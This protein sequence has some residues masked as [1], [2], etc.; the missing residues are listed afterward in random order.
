MQPLN[1]AWRE[2][3][4]LGKEKE[5]VNWAVLLASLTEGAGAEALNTSLLF[6]NCI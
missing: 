4:R 3:G 1:T 6:L 5:D 2:K